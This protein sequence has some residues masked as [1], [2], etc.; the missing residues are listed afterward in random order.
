MASRVA[1]VVALGEDVRVPTAEVAAF[2]DQAADALAGLL[3][4]EIVGVYFIGSVALDGYIPGESD[5]DIA[6]V[7]ESALTANQRQQLAAAIVEL[8]AAC[9]TRGLE[10]TRAGRG[11]SSSWTCSDPS[12]KVRS[13]RALVGLTRT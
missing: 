1:A 8:S 10:F 7:A 3:G 2:G 9:P 6:A 4:R 12:S 5:I 11:G 13:G